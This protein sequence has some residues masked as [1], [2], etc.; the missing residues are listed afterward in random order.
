MQNKYKRFYDLDTGYLER[1]S[2]TQLS[3]SDKK[4]LEKK[5]RLFMD[6]QALDEGDKG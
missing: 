2:R 1:F 4:L 3:F 5:L 6:E